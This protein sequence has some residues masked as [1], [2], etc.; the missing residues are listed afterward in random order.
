MRKWG[1]LFAGQGAQ[2]VGMA[3]DIYEGYEAA[4]EVIDRGCELLG[5][6]IRKVMFEG[7]EEELR[8]TDVS[9]P[10]IYLHSYASFRVIK[11]A[12]WFERGEEGAAGAAGLSLGE[13]TA[14][15]AA[16]WMDWEAGLSLVSRR[17]EL[18]QQAAAER[19]GTMA[20]V[21]GLDEETC[22]KACEEAAGSGTVT[23]ANLNSP[24]QVVISGEVEAV[25]EAGRLLKE[26]GA[27]RVIELNVAG[28]FHSPLMEK[29]AEGLKIA[30]SEV[31]FRKSDVP[32]ASNVTG[33]FI[34]SPEEAA[35]NLLRQLSGTVRFADC[36]QTIS[37]RGAGH[38]L[39]MG[40]GKVLS[41]LVKR[42]LNGAEVL[43]AG[44]AAEIGAVI[45]K[46]GQA[47]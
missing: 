36:L 8:K 14:L 13:Y 15:A 38:F 37:G 45:G 46:E 47:C 33:R 28:A 6:D 35:E 29:A 17:G 32:V 23:V 2:A 27:K 5:R 21:L 7:P 24:G 34:E 18:M 43:R 30:M 39:E 20:S 41:G 16:G 26:R 11:E 9:Q 3:K 44:T 42:T 4:R 25:R 19:P 40:P 10:A 22:R 31:S 12:G 1:L